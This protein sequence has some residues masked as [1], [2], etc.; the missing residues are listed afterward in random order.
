MGMAFDTARS[1]DLLL[2][3]DDALAT[4]SDA[5]DARSRRPRQRASS[6]RVRQASARPRS[7]ARSARASIRAPRSWSE[8]AIH[9]R[10]RARSGRCSTSPR[11][12]ASS[13]DLVRLGAPPSD[14]FAA[15]H[16]AAGGRQP[17]V[18]VL[19][20]LHWADEATLDV[21]RLLARRVE[22]L[23]VLV[24]VNVPRRRA[25]QRR[26]PSASSSVIWRRWRPSSASTSTRSRSRRSR[27]SRSATRSTPLELH[28]RTGGNPFFA[29]EVLASGRTTVPATVRDVVLGRVAAL[30]PERDPAR[31]DRRALAP[32]R[33]AM[34]PRG[35]SRR[36]GRPARRLP[37]LG[38]LVAGASH[39]SFRHE[40]A[41]IA[42][43]KSD[44]TDAS[45]CPA[46]TDPRGA[47]RSIRR[48]SSTTPGSRTMRKRRATQSPP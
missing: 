43:A 16:D 10:R 46:P 32:G 26:T 35:S 17:T 13:S 9:S 15:L 27:S 5:L 2:E 21:L 42:V 36:A 30:D 6:S 4:L 8:P 3:R 22:T 47:R 29:T 1:V 39:V 45:T 19:E 44:V 34:A 23:P 38:S 14:V 48:R 37:G 11:N 18:L 33:G 12:A 25:P 7:S 31:R 28:R 41:R 20:D 24:V 40:L